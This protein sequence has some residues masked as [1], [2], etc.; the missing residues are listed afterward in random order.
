MTSKCKSWRDVLP[1]H[2]AADL[3]P[4]MSESELRELGDDIR[5]NG[6]HEGV[7]LFDGQLLDGINRLDAMEMAGIKLVVGNGQFD[8]KSIGHRNVNGID[9]ITFVVSKNIHRRH[10]TAEQK[11]DLVTELI[12]R[13]PEKSDRQIAEQIKSNRTTVGQIRKKLEKSGDVSTIDTRTD[14]RGRKQPA[15]KKLTKDPAVI[16]AANRA[17][18]SA[19]RR[20][21]PSVSGR[22]DPID[23]ITSF[24]VQV[25]SDVLDVARRIGADWPILVERLR[26]VIDE[27]ELEVERWKKEPQPDKLPDIPEFLRRQTA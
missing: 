18:A 16:A 26:E 9:P 12:K 4:R 17:E 20:P 13:Q 19:N 8:W 5:R 25:R 6:L 2:P 21:E 1:I 22:G 3:F 10:L 14:A 11:R 7:A 24:T 27:L 15:H 23:L